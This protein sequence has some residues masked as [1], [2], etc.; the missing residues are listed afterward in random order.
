[1]SDIVT[2]EDRELV[3]DVMLIAN[4]LLKGG[5]WVARWIETG[6]GIPDTSP[7]WTSAIIASR[8]R[9]AEQK[10]M[11]A[12]VQGE[13]DAR[14]DA[15][16]HACRCLTETEA[17]RS[18]VANLKEEILQWRLLLQKHDEC[19]AENIA[20]RATLD[21]V[22]YARDAATEVAKKAEHEAEVWAH[23]ADH[24]EE[25]RHKEEEL[26]HKEEEL[27]HK[28]EELRHK[29]ENHATVYALS[30]FWGVWFPSAL[31]MT[32]CINCGDPASWHSA[33]SF[34][35]KPGG[36]VNCPCWGYQADLSEGKVR[37][38]PGRAAAA[39]GGGSGAASP[40]Q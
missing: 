1:M 20:L 26:R 25:L 14:L 40:R 15:E 30:E 27:R 33:G 4:S 3:T 34:C 28:E 23:V 16:K 11:Q 21:R 38:G 6:E 12:F 2:K 5:D 35:R 37:P 22:K 13:Q 24:E 36:G 7:L 10:R 39:P 29:A 19:S 31:A 17:L 8:A 9:V 18:E 32:T